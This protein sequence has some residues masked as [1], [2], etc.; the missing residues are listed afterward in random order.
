MGLIKNTKNKLA[1]K[2]RYKDFNLLLI[3]VDA[4]RADH[5]SC[6]GY[7][8]NTSPFISGLAKESIVFE[9]AF[10][11]GGW[12]LPSLA[13][14]FTSKYPHVHGVCNVDSRLSDKHTG[15]YTVD[16]RLSD[17]H[18]TLAEVLKNNGYKT[19]AFD[20]TGIWFLPV[21]NLGK[22][23]D[24][25]VTG[26]SHVPNNAKC[27]TKKLKKILTKNKMDKFFLYMH[28]FETHEPYTPPEEFYNK[29]NYKPN[30]N[31]SLSTLNDR[32]M[33]LFTKEIIT[34]MESNS[35]ELFK[36][37]NANTKREKKAII[38]L[39]KYKKHPTFF[40]FVRHKLSLTCISELIIPR[41]RSLVFKLF[42]QCVVSS[43]ASSKQIIDL[44]DAQI[45]YTDWMIGQL[46][47][48]LARLKLMDK[49]IIIITADHG[50]EFLEHG[51]YS[52]KQIYSEVAHVPLIIKIPGCESRRVT[53][54]AQLID[55]YPT[56]LG[57]LGIH[58]K[59]EEAQGIPL[60]KEMRQ[61]TNRYAFISKPGQGNDSAIRTKEWSFYLK[62]SGTNELYNLNDDPKEQQNVIKKFPL[63]AKRLHQEIT[64]ILE[65]GGSR[66]PIPRK[67]DLQSK[68][69]IKERLKA[70]GYI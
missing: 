19:L 30:K 53:E 10:A 51:C 29:L 1:S 11:Q 35:E 49:T 63:I 16:S 24:T 56:V 67:T 34:G 7:P 32:F 33:D 58:Y 45:R 6:Y 28:F 38:N 39:Y 48:H 69:E 17:K 14:L 8:R 41:W 13:S 26:L 43:K 27:N 52:H 50:E 55:I 54:L 2:P 21:F 65:Q 18:T 3:V 62:N 46:M 40:N 60:L 66:S 9:N 61:Q 64:K 37:L 36:T 44:Y 25:V 31:I 20:Q 4:L 47:G 42:W 57:L 70:L 5:L 15:V 68:K 12:T 59:R 23:F 22:G